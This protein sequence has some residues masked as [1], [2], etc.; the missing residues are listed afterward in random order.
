MKTTLKKEDWLTIAKKYGRDN[1]GATEL[2]AELGVSKQRIFQV[3]VTL[4]KNGIEVPKIQVSGGYAKEY[5]AFVK[6]NVS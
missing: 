4:R 6:S 2:A 3:V 1:V 5:I